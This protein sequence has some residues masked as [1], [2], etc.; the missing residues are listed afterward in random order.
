[1]RTVFSSPLLCLILLAVLPAQAETI[2]INDAKSLFIAVHK[3]E[4]SIPFR[5][6]EVEVLLGCK[7]HSRAD[8]V[9]EGPN[10][11]EDYLTE[12]RTNGLLKQVTL[13]EI[14]KPT[15]SFK[16]ILILLL[17]QSAKDATVADVRASFG[18]PDRESDSMVADVDPGGQAQT[19]IYDRAWGTLL[20]DVTKSKEH[21]IVKVV[22]QAVKMPTLNPLK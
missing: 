11:T 19:L 17:N 15:P 14:F 7:L 4:Q 13:N 20:F 21:Q 22:L 9:V 18:K 5:K 1:M 6:K 12:P 8:I 16:G 3:L 10:D 2:D